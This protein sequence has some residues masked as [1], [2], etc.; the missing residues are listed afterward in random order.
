MVEL[1]VKCSNC[2]EEVGTG[3]DMDDE[4][5]EKALLK[6]STTE[7]PSCGEEISWGKGDVINKDEL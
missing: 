4:Q 5:F 6:G 2:G 7:C 1:K 3:M